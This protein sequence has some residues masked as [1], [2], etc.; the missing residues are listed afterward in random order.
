M[1]ME[2]IALLFNDLIDE[3]KFLSLKVNSIKNIIDK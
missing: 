1:E 2:R 3:T